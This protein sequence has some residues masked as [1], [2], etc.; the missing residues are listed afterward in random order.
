MV[1]AVGGAHQIYILS[2]CVVGVCMC[3]REKKRRGSRMY[4]FIVCLFVFF[5][6]FRKCVMYVV[7]KIKNCLK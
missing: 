6:F 7:C 2:L 5:L 4:L 1:W 3:E